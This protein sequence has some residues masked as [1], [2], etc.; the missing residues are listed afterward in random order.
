MASLAAEGF[1][2]AATA[3]TLQLQSCYAKLGRTL[4]FLNTLTSQYFPD[5]M[6]FR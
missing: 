3:A 2:I 1:T 5:K 6:P 4:Y